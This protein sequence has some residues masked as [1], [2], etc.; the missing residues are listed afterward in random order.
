MNSILINADL[1]E[2]YGLDQALFP[3]IDVANIACGGHTGNAQTIQTACQLA[4]Q[5][6]VQVGAHPSYP[7]RDGFGRTKPTIS[8]LALM[9]SLNQQMALFEQ[10]AQ[11]VGC[12]PSHFKPHGQLY[13]DAAFDSTMAQLVIELA[14]QYPHLHLYVLAY[15]PLELMAKKAGVNVVSEGF[16]DRAYLS[17]YSLAPRHLAGAILD[18][19]ELVKKQAQ[20]MLF[21]Q[22]IQ[23]LDRACIQLKVQSLCVHGDTQN[24]LLNAKVVRQVLTQYNEHLKGASHA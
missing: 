19:P 16:P 21:G 8:N 18:K 11:S 9:D 6:Q 10:V 4:L 3:F 20:A 24:A 5:H 12:K 15:S 1:G 2:G 22:G 23:T 14:L 7:D 13:N 17:N